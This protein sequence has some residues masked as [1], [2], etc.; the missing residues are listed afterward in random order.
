V[1]HRL[2]YAPPADDGLR[3]MPRRSEFE[4]AMATTIA[5]DP[6]GHGSTEV[7]GDRDRRDAT[8]AGAIVRYVVSATVLTVTVVR[9]ISL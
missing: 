2:A 4:S 9:L 1:R 3:K 8:V 7:G 5:R 6:Y